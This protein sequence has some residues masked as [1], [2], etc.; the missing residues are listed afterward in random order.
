MIHF[1]H[2][3]WKTFGVQMILFFKL[4]VDRFNHSPHACQWLEYTESHRVSL[5]IVN[6]FSGVNDLACQHGKS[7][8]AENLESLSQKTPKSLLRKTCHLFFHMGLCKCR[9]CI[10]TTVHSLLCFT[11]TLQSKNFKKMFEYNS[12]LTRIKKV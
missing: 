8:K 6:A 11:K 2:Y 9:M 3:A 10:E 7:Y 5:I 12:M 4:S 1:S